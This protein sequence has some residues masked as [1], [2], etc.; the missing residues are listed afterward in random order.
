MQVQIMNSV[1]LNDKNI[2]NNVGIF[3]YDHTINRKHKEQ[4]W[5]EQYFM[6]TVTRV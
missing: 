2:V 4:D 3:N 6:G 1:G 5:D